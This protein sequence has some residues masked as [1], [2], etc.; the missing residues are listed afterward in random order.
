MAPKKSQ[1][2][3]ARLH[4]TSVSDAEKALASICATT[5]IATATS[6]PK[7]T[8]KHTRSTTKKKSIFI[9]K[10]ILEIGSDDSD[11]SDASKLPNKKNSLGRRAPPSPPL[12]RRSTTTGSNQK[13]LKPTHH[14]RETRTNVPDNN[15]DKGSNNNDDC[16]GTNDSSNIISSTKGRL[17][18]GIDDVDNSDNFNFNTDNDNNRPKK[19]R[20]GIKNKKGHQTLKDIEEWEIAVP[21]SKCDYVMKFKES[22]IRNKIQ[23]KDIDLSQTYHPRIVNID[24]KLVPGKFKDISAVRKMRKHHFDAHFDEI[25]DE[26]DLPPLFR[27]GNTQYCDEQRKKKQ[28]TRNDLLSKS[29]KENEK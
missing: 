5:A 26:D 19:T 25:V 29:E 24:W 15:N 18:I 17:K 1:K 16:F 8:I 4:R 7:P 3:T 20:R 22:T 28:R 9:K 13:S 2:I 23:M 21:C 6:T 10:S 11:D 12:T 27:I 14:P